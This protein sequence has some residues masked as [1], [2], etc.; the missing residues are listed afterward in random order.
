MT[1]HDPPKKTMLER[2]FEQGVAD[3]LLHGMVVAIGRDAT[4]DCLWAAGNAA[5]APTVRPMAVDAV[6]NIASITK[7]VVTAT[8]CGILMDQGKLDPEAPARHYLPEFTPRPKI[9]IRVRDLATHTS[10]LANEKFYARPGDEMMRLLLSAP[11]S[12]PPRSRYCYACRN[13]VLLGLIVERL[14]GVSLETFVREHI[15]APLGMTSSFG[16]PP[17]AATQE[18]MV[19]GPYPP[20]NPDMH[21]LF[22]RAGHMLGHAGLFTSAPDL[23]RFSAMMLNRGQVGSKR[24]LG[25]TAIEWL[26]KPCS[27]AGLPPRSFG[28]DMRPPLDE[29]DS[30]PAE[31]TAFSPDRAR[32][33]S[34]LAFGHGGWTGQSLWVDPARN[35]YLMVLTNRTHC[36][37]N[38]DNY[39]AGKRFRRKVAE[40]LLIGV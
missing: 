23:A 12:W 39:E 33:L 35:L 15:F 37:R 9:E 26:T 28:W 20:P 5:V 11:I 25:E 38:P 13:Y 27:P 22:V 18:R 36:P 30:S 6:F 16:Y 2:L 32:G 10:G 24:I 8:A 4:P 1:Q 21:S 7:A 34:A 29:S 31:S 3:G 17:P 40:A 14:T 19:P